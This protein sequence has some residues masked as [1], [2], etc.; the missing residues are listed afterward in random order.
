MPAAKKSAAAKSQT[1]KEAP[2]PKGDFREEKDSLGIV[3][4]PADALY[5]VQTWR[6]FNNF[7]VTG[8]RAYPEMIEAFVRIKRASVE[9]T[10][11]VGGMPKEIAKAIL[12][13]ADEVL[14]GKYRDQFIIDVFQAG[15]GTSFNM[16][17]NEVLANRA[18]ELL[19]KPRGDYK[20]VSPNDHVNFGQSTNDSFPTA[21]RL[22]CLDRAKV[23]VPIV[24]SLAAAFERK[25]KE[26]KDYLKTGR[27]H[28]QDAV[29]VTLGQE[30][31]AYGKALRKCARRLEQAA[32]ECLELPIGGNAL[33]TGVNTPDGFRPEVVKNLSKYTG[34]KLRVGEDPREV[35]QSQRPIG[36]VS[37]ALRELAVELSRISSDLRLLCSG[38]SSGFAEI[39]L[40]A[41]Q[42]GS[43]IMPGKI[44][45]VMAECLNMVC[46]QVIG[47][48]T[49]VQLGVVHGQ[50]D[51]NVMMPGMIFATLFSFNIFI[52]YLPQFEK[53]CVDGIVADKE[54]CQGYLELNPSLATLLNP[55]IGYMAA[56]EIA[57]QSVK[58]KRSV[59][60]IVREKKI[61]TEAQIKDVFGPANLTGHLDKKGN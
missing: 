41:V 40:P 57:K 29:P 58:E 61:L 6:G 37:S 1:I 51:L 10:L 24:E 7:Q 28:L 30:F 42:P 2:A 17:T 54:R 53:S 26:W 22:A 12:D 47:N 60:D 25:G 20:S 5:G 49:A 9:A 36:A 39:V 3:K 21:M 46:F 45:P 34:F 50:L 43:S 38:P 18:L 35:I 11:K 4:V 59:L 33:G 31:T 19:G 14:D 23:L 52:N 16:N 27:T 15:A 56:A 44:N 55:F 32:E 13:A 8:W 48:D